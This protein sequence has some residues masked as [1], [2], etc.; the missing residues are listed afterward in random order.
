MPPVRDLLEYYVSL[1]KINDFVL[2]TFA[3]R[4]KLFL[5]ILNDFFSNKISVI[6]VCTLAQYLLFEP[7]ESND[8]EQ[9]LEYVLWCCTELVD[10]EEQN[11]VYDQRLQQHADLIAHMR[12]YLEKHCDVVSE[13]ILERSPQKL[14]C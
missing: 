13:I 10:T 7:S 4:Q 1:V 14:V 2:L 12:K 9:E 11:R 6:D 3:Q 5:L 8:D